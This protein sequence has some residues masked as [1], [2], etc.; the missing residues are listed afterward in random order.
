M[1]PFKLGN[2]VAGQDLASVVGGH[3]VTGHSAH[4]ASAVLERGGVGRLTVVVLLIAAIIGAIAAIVISMPSKKDAPREEVAA[5]SPP[6]A[7]RPP[8]I[9]DLATSVGK[10]SP[11]MAPAPEKPVVEEPKPVVE[12]K[13]VVTEDKPVTETVVAPDNVPPPNTPDP[14]RTPPRPDRKIATPKKDPG[15]LRVNS[16]PWAYVQIAGQKRV[17]APA[18]FTLQPGKYAVRFYRADEELRKSVTKYVTIESGKTATLSVNLE[19]DN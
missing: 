4:V 9:S 19:E 8:E 18:K 11:S 2:H 5:V 13:P 1:P 16:E 17:D 15:F 12:D 6:P 14:N 10:A 7:A 3:T